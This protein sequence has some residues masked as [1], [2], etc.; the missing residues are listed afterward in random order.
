MFWSDV[1]RALQAQILVQSADFEIKNFA[2]ADLLSDI[3]ASQ[4]DDFVILTGQTSPQS[5]R[6]AVAVGAL[7]VIIVRGKQLPPESINVART[8]GVPLAMTTMKMFES[9]VILGGRLWNSPSSKN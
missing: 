2:A 8:Y 4:K 5:I 9:C 1:I 6:T 3:L 7:G